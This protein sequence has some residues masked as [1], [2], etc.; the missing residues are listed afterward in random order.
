M[1]LVREAKRSDALKIVTFQL[2]MALET[3]NLHL[4]R[5]VV[6][7]GVQAVFDDRTK[8]IYYVA[9]SERQVIGSF[10]ITYEWSDW[11]NGQILWL[12]SVYVLPGF[13]GKGVFK[14]MYK[15]L[16]QLIVTTENYCGVRLYVEKNNK[17]ARAVYKAMGMHDHHYDMYEWMKE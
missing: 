11:R 8:G 16:Q 5:N 7:N 17:A 1:Y 12:Q 15:H 13:R 9:E 4:D 2:E 6:S 14:A 10:L 3:E